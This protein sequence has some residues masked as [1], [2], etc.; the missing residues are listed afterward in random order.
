MNGQC[1]VQRCTAN[2]VELHRLPLRSTR[3]ARGA[4][5]APRS[6]D[7]GPPP[8]A[9][10]P[11][12]HSRGRAPCPSG[13]GGGRSRGSSRS[14]RPATAAPGRPPRS[15]TTPATRRDTTRPPVAGLDSAPAPARPPPCR[16]DACRGGPTDRR[17]SEEHTS[18]LQSHV[19]LVCRLLLEKQK[20]NV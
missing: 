17:R 6:P 10:T 8:A 19:N 16:Y 20:E 15:A 2:C 9:K 5:H 13:I 11:S 1:G 12:R 4:R 3:A 14:A 18:E 7:S